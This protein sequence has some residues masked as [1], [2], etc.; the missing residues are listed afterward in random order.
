MAVLI[1][2]FYILPFFFIIGVYP[3]IGYG[4]TTPF[5]FFKT[6]LLYETARK[7]IQA[8][9]SI[10]LCIY[11]FTDAIIIFNMIKSY[12]GSKTKIFI[13]D[14]V[15]NND[16][17]NTA[18]ITRR[19]IGFQIMIFSVCCI[20]YSTLVVAIPS[21]IGLQ[22]SMLS[23]IT[24]IQ[25]NQKEWTQCIFANKDY[26]VKCK[27]TPD[28]QM[29]KEYAILSS[30]IFGGQSIVVGGI[31]ILIVLVYYLFF[32]KESAKIYKE[33]TFME[34]MISFHDFFGKHLPEKQIVQN[35]FVREDSEYKKSISM[36]EDFI[37]VEEMK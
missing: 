13:S 17:D 33:H 31:F 34:I 24:S 25:S 35:I 14:D 20:I 28:L 18:H 9:Y 7:S 4:K 10:N 1:G 3:S 15:S 16:T 32:R 19:N 26:D 8:F 5:C 22:R 36:V 11:V 23:F 6:V 29:S 21:I 12:P 30:I 2:L 27:D 37:E